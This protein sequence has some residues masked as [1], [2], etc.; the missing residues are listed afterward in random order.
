[1]EPIESN[2]RLDSKLRTVTFVLLDLILEIKMPSKT[3]SV[4][5]LTLYS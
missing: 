5:L 4:Y 2:K 1:M 3:N